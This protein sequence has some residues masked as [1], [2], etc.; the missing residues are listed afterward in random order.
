MDHEVILVTI[1]YRLNVFGFLSLGNEEVPGNAGLKDQSLA[2]NWIQDNIEAFGGDPNQVTIFGESAGSLSVSLQ[3]LS[4]Y[5]EGLFQRVIMESGTALGKAWS[6]ITSDH[7]LEYSS[8][9]AEI[10]NCDQSEDVL[11][12]LQEQTIEDIGNAG[13]LNDYTDCWMCLIWNAIP[14]Y[15]FT[16]QPFIPN[17]PKE[18]LASGDFNKNIDVIIGTNKDEGILYV[19][20]FFLD[21]ELWNDWRENFYN[22]GTRSL[23]NIPKES[24][25]TEEDIENTKQLVEYYFGTIENFNEEHKTAVFNLFTDGAFLFDTHKTINY[26]TEA[27]VTVYEYIMTYQGEYSLTSLSGF[28]PVGVCHADELLYLFTP[29]FSTNITLN[30]EDIEVKNVMVK[31]WTNF[32]KFGDPTPPNSDFSWT[33]RSSQDQVHHFLNISGP[34]PTMDT[35]QDIED[36][37][38]EWET[39][40][41]KL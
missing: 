20:G 41:G 7:V 8:L 31:A 29:A 26:L 4:P 3:M 6:K 21:P 11:A 24:D 32:A 36:R 14:D 5:S 1:N 30:A 34:N 19:L 16:N 23:F 12:C 27:G 38:A 10:L 18:L 2:L 40:F 17:E 37:I 39:I 25:I 33:P 15:E 28:G 13:R 22:I 9:L 35:S